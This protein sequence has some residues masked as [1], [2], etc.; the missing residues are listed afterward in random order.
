MPRNDLR[1][2]AIVLR[3][4]K[5]GETDRILNLLTPLGMRSVVARG[6]RKERSKLAG[7]IEMFCLSDV[8]IHEG[9]GDLGT[10][11]S[12]KMLTFYQNILR[13]LDRLELGSTILK[14]AARLADQ[15]DTPDLFGLVKQDLEGLNSGLNPLLI[16]SWHH[17]NF[18][19]LSGKDVNLLFD[20]TG[21]PLS[22]SQHYAWNAIDEALE[23]VAAGRIGASEIKLL[24]LMT[25]SSLRTVALV[26][27]LDSL[28]PEVH[29]VAQRIAE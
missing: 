9:K 1:T 18:A 28:L 20:T 13:D 21:A 26:K 25:V 8:V 19:R 24:R 23:P 4:T 29:H 6:V 22:P 15:V 12:A 27:D 14:Q 2:E 10:L 5:Y 17:L 11:T 16:E 3:R 7:G